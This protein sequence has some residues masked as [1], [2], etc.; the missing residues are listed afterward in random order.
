MHQGAA[1][2]LYNTEF[3]SYVASSRDARIVSALNILFMLQKI[4][5]IKSKQEQRARYM[6]KIVN[7][8]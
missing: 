5:V 2:G 4:Q 1:Q 3:A 7:I 8:K 6:V